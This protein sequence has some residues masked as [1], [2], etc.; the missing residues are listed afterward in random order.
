MLSAEEA[1]AKGRVVIDDILDFINDIIL[2][3]KAL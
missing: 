1:R 3:G 2:Y